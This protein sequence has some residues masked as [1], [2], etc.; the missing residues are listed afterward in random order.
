MMAIQHTNITLHGSTVVVLGLGRVG[1]TL[2]RTLKA[3]GAHVRVGVR[4]SE[5]FARADE[6]RLGPFY[7]DHLASNVRDADI[8]FNTVPAHVVTAEVIKQMPGHTLIIDLAS[9]PGGTDFRYAEKRG[10][11]AMLAPSLPGIVAPK[12][13]GRILAVTLS[14]L[15]QDRFVNRREHRELC[16][17]NGRLRTAGS[18]CTHDQVL[19]QMQRLVDLGAEV[20]P[21]VSYT[22]ANVD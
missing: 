12:T 17:K 4:K 19:P 10:I 9:K 5:H 13:A 7:T 16:W 22:V 18:H 14:Q 15:I 2:S 21:V 1:L 20:I 8:V 3:L 6:M 11:K